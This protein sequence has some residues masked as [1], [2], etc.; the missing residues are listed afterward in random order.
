VGQKTQRSL[1]GRDRSDGWLAYV[2]YMRGQRVKTDSIEETEKTVADLQSQ[3]D[4][5]KKIRS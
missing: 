2:G 4:A 1:P 3:I 5:I